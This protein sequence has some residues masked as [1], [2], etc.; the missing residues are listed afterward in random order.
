MKRIKPTKNYED[1]P[2]TIGVEEYMEWRG[3][4]RAIADA[5]FHQENFP[6]IRGTGVKLL[7]DKRAVL[8]FETGLSNEDRQEVLKEIARQIIWKEKTMSKYRQGYVKALKDISLAIPL[9]GFYTY[10]LIRFLI[11]G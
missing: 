8:L 1:L 3:C 9:M 5:V 7:A 2:D 10:V 6:R 4:G 11:G